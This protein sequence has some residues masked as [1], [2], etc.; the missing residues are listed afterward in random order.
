MRDLYLM[1]VPSTTIHTHMAQETDNEV[2]ELLEH[3]KT[4][5][6]VRFDLDKAIHGGCMALHERNPRRYTFADTMQE[7]VKA[8]VKALKKKKTTTL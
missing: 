7:I 2:K 6:A 8:G 1:F 4:K 5:V 3:G